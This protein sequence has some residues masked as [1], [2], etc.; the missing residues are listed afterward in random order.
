MVVDKLGVTK[1]FV[2]ANPVFDVKLP[3]QITPP[4]LDV[5][6]KV[7]L[8]VPQ[9]VAGVVE[10]TVGVVFIVATTGVLGEEHPPFTASA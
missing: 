9:R 8:P 2:L 7:T 1:L 3:Y 6:F 4:A 10:V 5:A